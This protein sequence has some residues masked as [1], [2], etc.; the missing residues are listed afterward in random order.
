MYHT[1]MHD[2][3]PCAQRRLGRSQLVLVRSSSVNV[4]AY[5]V[6]CVE[7]PLHRGG[8]DDRPRACKVN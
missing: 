1:N 3:S 6:V 7:H 2:P 4:E 8:R 5:K